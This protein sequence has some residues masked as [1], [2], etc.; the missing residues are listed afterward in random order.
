MGCL[1]NF[2]AGWIF[3]FFFLLDFEVMLTWRGFHLRLTASQEVT[4]FPTVLFSIRHSLLSLIKSYLVRI[5]LL[6]AISWDSEPTDFNLER[7]RMKDCF[8]S[9]FL[10]FLCLFGPCFLYLFNNIWTDLC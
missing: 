2:I 10:G 6:H 3:F 5:K 9:Y 7:H 1:M 4:I 8:Q